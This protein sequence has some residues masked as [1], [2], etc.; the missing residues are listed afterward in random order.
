MFRDLRALEGMEQLSARL[1]RLTI[2]RFLLQDGP[3]HHL[4]QLIDAL[5]ASDVTQAAYRYHDMTAAL[6]SSG[7]RRVSGSLFTD[8]L[9]D[10]LV[11]QPNAFSAMSA[12]GRL[13]EPVY[14]AMGAELTLMGQ[15]STLKG[16][17]LA[18]YIG[19]RLQELKLKPRQAKDIISLMSN[20]AWAGSPAK[21]LQPAAPEA[22]V[23]LL[24]LPSTLQEHTW[25]SWQY[26]P[27][28]FDGSFVSDQAL[29]EIYHRLLNS[30]DWRACLDDLWNFF[31]TCGSGPFLKDR[32]F[33]LD[34][35]V[36]VPMPEDALPQQD[37]L[38]F[39]ETQRTA[40][41]QHV[42]RFMRGEAPGSVLVTGGPGSG[43]TT[44]VLSLVKELPEV[45]LVMTDPK[46]AEGLPALCRELQR[47]PLR[48]LLYV[49]AMELSSP[50]YDR[51]R[52][53]LQCG[54]IGGDNQLLCISARTGDDSVFHQ[55]VHLGVPTLKE[56]IAH[57]EALL[58]RQ[59]VLLDYDRIQ[60]ACIDV[61]NRTELSFTAARRTAAALA[62]G[63]C[64]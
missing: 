51:L 24:R 22:A 42:I 11:C 31:A 17:T 49:D 34:R 14:A 1:C 56:F 23:P 53:D 9:L 44:L 48:F 21:P 52:A 2:F 57:V 64:P 3:L 37:D 62:E 47:Q 61:A 55:R 10:A 6:L 18:R 27:P 39:Y 32:L 15:L 38:T 40:L 30:E 46:N 19:D 4:L 63:L 50:E 29:E 45:R 43:K 41:T 54:R 59:G 33:S 5:G 8:Y 58:Q 25:L 35:G 20:A 7:A 16:S 60:N 36:L 13:D 28:V 12:E 26:D